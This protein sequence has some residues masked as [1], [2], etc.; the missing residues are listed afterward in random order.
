MLETPLKYALNK[1]EAIEEKQ[2]QTS[3]MALNAVGS[4]PKSNQPI[5]WLK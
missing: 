5:C 1:K 4:N 3:A 2:F